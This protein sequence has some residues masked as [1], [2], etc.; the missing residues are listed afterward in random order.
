MSFGD[1]VSLLMV[2]FVLLFS[3][4]TLDEEKFS[5][6]VENFMDVFDVKIQDDMINKFKEEQLRLQELY[7]KIT[8]YIEQEKLQNIISVEKGSHDLKID[9]SSGMLFDVASATLK[10]SASEILQ[11]LGGFLGSLEANI[12]VEGHTDDIPIHVK[13]FPSNWELSSARAS[14]VV[15]FLIDLGIKE[16]N[17]YIV[18]FG[19]TKPIAANDSEENRSR[20]RRVRLVFTPISGEE[21]SINVNAISNLDSGLEIVTVNKVQNT[22]T[23]ANKG[24]STK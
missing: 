8:A 20:N 9:F 17:C 21:P 4:S 3:M 13:E 23:S 1:M 2:M 7:Q 22:T 15:R 6:V 18:G 10:E 5:K 19:S 14:S 12:I 11:K 24:I 16:N